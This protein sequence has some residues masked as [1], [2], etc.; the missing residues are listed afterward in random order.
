M[1]PF[2][3]LCRRVYFASQNCGICT[4]GDDHLILKA[5]GESL[6]AVVNEA[7]EKLELIA[8]KIDFVRDRRLGFIC[9]RPQKCGTGLTLTASFT[10]VTVF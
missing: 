3:P 8:Q 7:K 10:Q 5:I 4:L 2:W 1:A 6:P 9:N